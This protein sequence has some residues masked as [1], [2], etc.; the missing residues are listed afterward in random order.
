MLDNDLFAMAVSS[1]HATATAT[2]RYCV[3]L[4]G[5]LVTWKI[6]EETVVARSSAEVECKAMV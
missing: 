5:N 1:S 3:L 2:S 6:N 4:S